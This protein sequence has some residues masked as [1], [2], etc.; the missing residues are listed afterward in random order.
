MNSQRISSRNK[1][2]VDYK[3]LAEEG[4]KVVVENDPKIEDKELGTKPIKTKTNSEKILSTSDADKSDEVKFTKSPSASKQTGKPVNL[5]KKA[6]LARL[7]E[8]DE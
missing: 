2:K 5:E 7:N 4:V 8:L 1:E 6:M 3:M